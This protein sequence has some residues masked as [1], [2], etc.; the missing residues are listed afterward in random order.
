[1]RNARPPVRSTRRASATDRTAN[2]TDALLVSALALVLLG[3]FLWPFVAR[4]TGFPLGPDAPVYLWWSRLAGAEGLSAIAH[5][6]GAPALSLVLEGTLAL[7]VIQ[8]TAALEVVL[9]VAVGLSSAALVRRRT[10][11]VGS[12]LAGL[13]AGTFAVHLAAGYL[14]NLVTAAAFLAAGALLDDPRRRAALLA[15]VVLAGGGLAHPLFFM[16]A[17]SVLLV[18]AAGAW[19]TDRREARRL[20]AA[21]VG[22]SALVGIGLLAVRPGAPRLPTDTSKDAFLRRAGLISTLRHEYLDRL[23]HRSARYVPWISVPLALVGWPSPGG[24]AGRILRA[25]FGVTVVGFMLG[26]VTGRLPAE[27]FVMFGFAISILAGL[28]IV[29]IWLVLNHHR[30]VAVVT[31]TALTIGML[32]GAGAWFR[33][34]PFITEQE[35][36]AVTI[37]HDAIVRSDPG[38]PLAF[39]VNEPDETVAFLATRAG[40]VIRAAVP[41]DRIRDVVIVVPPLRAG[42]TSDERR[43]LERLTARDLE[44]AETTSG[45]SAAVFVLTPFD[46]VDRPAGAVVVD[47]S[48]PVNDL[49]PIDP[50]EPSSAV[51]IAW[52]SI[53][54]LALLWVAGY[55]WARIG[56]AD[57]I[58]AAAAAPAIGA[59]MLILVATALDALGV[60]LG[61]ATGALAAS[62][63]AGGGGYLIRF[64]LER[65]AGSGAAPQVEEQP[66]E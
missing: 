9:G 44:Q 12:A 18:A 21:A 51:G 39:L 62:A 35:V 7:S 5:R 53:A 64:V 65:R 32:G 30:A 14:A 52:A 22:A 11:A 37:A 55:G 61:S 50:L 1:M 42:T 19:R 17:V 66:A 36:R 28:G 8:A 45:R 34:E 6:P 59:A 13:L 49:V 2:R 26:V 56:L 31:G 41:P 63:L 10:G 60:P 46:E 58:T 48:T 47:P 25:W 33:E 16:V 40:N 29:R 4:G 20:A 43:A 15:A 23:I 54:T 38:T 3:W 27:R 24:N 57:T